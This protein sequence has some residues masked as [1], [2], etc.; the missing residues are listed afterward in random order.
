M[1]AQREL[2]ELWRRSDSGAANRTPNPANMI[3]TSLHNTFSW[4]LLLAIWIF[5]GPAHAFVYPEHRD[6]AIK[7]VENLDPEHRAVFDKLWHEARLTKERRLCEQGADATQSVM[8]ACIDWAALTA[9]AGDHSCSS[10]DLTQ[11]VLDSGW[12]LSV[13]DVAAQLKLDL[14]RIDV[15][16]PAAQ[17]PGSK[18]AIVDLQRR[19][20]TESAR[21][22]RLN[23][24]RTADNRLQRADPQY[25]TRAG[26][27]NAHFLL[28]RPQ[29]STTP[30][31]YGAL[32]MRPGSEISAIGVYAW[33]HLSAMQKATRL[34]TEQLAPEARAALVRAMLFDEAFGLHFLEDVFAA[35]HVAG[36]WGGTA[37]RKGTHDFYNEAGLEV[38]LWKGSSESM[39]LMGDAHMRPEDAERASASVRTSIEQLLDTAAGKS[40]AANLP[41]TPAAS[42]EPDPFN[43]C[44]NNHLVERPE[45]LS[46]AP[47]AYRDAYRTDLREV[48][49]PTPVPGLGPGLGA[50]PRFRS[51]VGPFVGMA[52]MIDARGIEGGFTV[53]GGSG[54]IGGVEIAAKAGLGLDGVMSDSGDGLVFVSLGLR[55]DFASTNAIAET[56]L[57]QAGGDLTAAIPARTALTVRL[58]MPYYVIPGDLLFLS[59]LY[60]VS[61][62]RYQNMAVVA[63]NGGLI[64]WQSGLAT[65]IGRF[66]FVLGRELGITFYGLSGDDR[67]IASSASLGG[68]ARLIEYK[69]ISYDMPIFEYRPYRAFASNQSTTLLFQLFAA[70]D[71]PRSVSV[72]SPA[73]D[74]VPDLRTVWSVGLRLV[75]DW[76]Y[77]P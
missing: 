15:L 68:P 27:N 30:T 70:A 26:S 35:G 66:Q 33:Y 40:R 65:G 44:K 54:F 56:P 43:V 29:T 19:I 72:V 28:P 12:I 61:P 38:F 6:I 60:F 14:S 13:A 36:T 53:P 32:T 50:M 73:G 75:F 25:A 16:P 7:A 5:T 57:A 63:G 4:L 10:Q 59:P 69:S 47:E 62:E 18:D 55:G 45:P 34:A 20:Q 52:G 48:L 46:A 51:E 77:Y 3:P 58:R 8:P 24:L 22:E 1:T 67:V 9:I 49:A 64:P 74:P 71:V 2:T 31:E 76:R 42:V 39:V 23:A 37:Q 17:V 41:H 11:I 21:A